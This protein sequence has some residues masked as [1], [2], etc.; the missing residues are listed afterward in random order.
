[1]STNATRTPVQAQ[2]TF[3]AEAATREGYGKGLTELAAD[4]RVVVLDA[5]LSKS[6]HSASFAKAGAKDRFL[7]MGIAEANM[8]GVAAGLASCGKV[9]YASSFAIFATQRALNHVFQSICYPRLNVKIG[10]SH[11]GVT[12]GEDG[13]THQALDDI[14]NMR[15]LPNMTVVVPADF[16]EAK[17]FT[18]AAA[19]FEGPIY[20][21]FGRAKVPT[22]YSPEHRVRI[23]RADRLREGKDVSLIACGVMVNEALKAADLLA[24]QGISADVINCATVKPLDRETILESAARTGAV[25]TAE[26]HNI[27]G[28]LG[29]A[30]AEL[31]AEEH[32]TPMRRVGVEDMFGQSG[33]ASQLLKEYGL[34][35]ENIADK[36]RNLLA[37]VR[38]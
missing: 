36:A 18:L 26:E 13:A 21:R 4:P 33:T 30:V 23:G 6:T 11:A 24:Q 7:N 9:V 20:L 27:L 10:A 5:D 28:G 25:V 1:M 19:E 32:P 37:K 29:G 16:A 34:T 22:L 2:A 15:A 12:V 3:P 8:M 31:L 35:A 14:A 17:L 38:G